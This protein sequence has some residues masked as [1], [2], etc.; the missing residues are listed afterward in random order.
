MTLSVA[1]Q[2][3]WDD[4]LAR[5]DAIEIHTGLKEAPPPPAVELA[6]TPTPQ[7]A[8]DIKALLAQLVAKLG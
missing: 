4:V 2:R 1:E 6:P 8:S 5:L 7:E 3:V